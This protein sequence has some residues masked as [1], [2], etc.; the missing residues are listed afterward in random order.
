[1]QLPDLPQVARTNATGSA[2][3]S[4]S[5]ALGTA[6]R[7]AARHR[8]LH[9]HAAPTPGCDRFIWIQLKPSEPDPEIAIARVR[10]LSASR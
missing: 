9:L 5:S 8:T 10:L 4:G 7:A 2:E 3:V 1:M 6:E